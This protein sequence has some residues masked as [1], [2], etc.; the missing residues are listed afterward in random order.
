MSTIIGFQILLIVFVRT[1][2]RKFWEII[3]L[4]AIGILTTFLFGMSVGRSFY[5]FVLWTAVAFSFLPEADFRF[6]LYN[7]FLLFQGLVVF[8]GAAIG[9]FY[10]FP[11]VLS[12]EKRQE[13][14]HSTAWQYSAA[15]WVNQVLPENAVVLSGL[16]SV[17]LFTNDFVPTDW[18]THIK[19]NKKYFDAV[20]LKKPNFL[21]VSST[22]KGL[23]GFAGEKYA[24]TKI[25]NG[26][27]K[28]LDGCAGEKYAGPITFKA[29]TRNPFNAGEEWFVIIYHFDSSLL[30]SCKR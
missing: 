23:D 22:I 13:V 15:S 14:M 28:S 9:G 18:L 16:R 25:F 6:R 11:G 12:K 7:R 2:N 30:P 24:R 19:F 21:V 29:A 3:A 1:K 20:R 10:L 4:T 17:A 27:M 26:K 8:L 5:E